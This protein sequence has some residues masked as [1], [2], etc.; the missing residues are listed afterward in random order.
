MKG[1]R[2]CS[3]SA[4]FPSLEKGL[5][6]NGLENLYLILTWLE[7]TS[8]NDLY[9]GWWDGKLWGEFPDNDIPVFIEAAQYCKVKQIQQAVD[10]LEVMICTGVEGRGIMKNV[11]LLP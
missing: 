9:R 8:G 4:R 1:Q 7:F 11:W 2:N 5:E 3:L 6:R 10:L